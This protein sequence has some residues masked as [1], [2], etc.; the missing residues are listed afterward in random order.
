MD[1]SIRGEKPAGTVV[2]R[3]PLFQ[4][5]LSICLLGLV[6][7]APPSA[8]GYTV[9]RINFGANVRLRTGD[10][11]HNGTA[12]GNG[13]EQV[14]DQGTL[15][16]ELTD[17]SEPVDVG[18]TA[19]VGGGGM[20]TASID[21]TVAITIRLSRA[22]RQACVGPEDFDIT[23]NINSPLPGAFASSTP[24][25]GSIQVTGFEP[26]YRGGFGNRCP[27]SLFYGYRMDLELEGALADGNYQAT[28]D[29]EVTF[30]GGATEI[31]QAPLEIQMPS[32]LLLYHRGQINVNLN[33]SALAGAFGASSACGDD[34]CMDLGS[35]TL[36]LSDTTGIV[37]VGISDPGFNPLQTINLRGAIGA[38]G[39]GCAGG[40]YGTA[41]YEIVT[42]VGGIQ[43]ASGIISGIQNSPCSMTLRTGD[44]PV[45]LD[46]T[47]LDSATGRASATI[48]IT[49]TGL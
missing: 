32:V 13:A 17:F 35:R 30:N 22:E 45:D 10:I 29:V 40:I 37:P 15:N 36:T 12:L 39:V 9:Q 43:T 26:V 34:Y 31:I 23:L 19:G 48:Q 8:H 46:L 18:I 38:R 21:R 1:V 47:Q 6:Q 49:V 5:I 28:A 44:L 27:N 2:V 4:T 33:A 7:V 16:A 3:L 24:G 25:G 14:F 20:L 41:T 11:V 42:A